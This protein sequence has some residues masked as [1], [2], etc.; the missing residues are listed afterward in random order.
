[1]NVLV[2]GGAGYLGGALT[3]LLLESAHNFRVYDSLVYE[4]CFLKEVDFIGGD[5]RDTERLKKQLSW[6]DVVIWLVGIVGDGACAID[7]DLTREI[8]VDAVKFLVNNYDGRIVYP[9][10]CSVY[11]AQHNVILTENSNTNPLSVYAVTK[12]E[13]EELLTDKNAIIYR[14]GTLFGLGDRYSR[15]RLD[16]VVN[17][18]V[19]KAHTLGK[20]TVFGGEQFRPLLHVKDVAKTMLYN[21]Q[22]SIKGIFNIHKQNTRIMD[23][24][25]Q[26][27]NH[28]PDVEVVH[29][30][31]K[32][33]DSRNYRVSSDK[34]YEWLVFKPQYTI[35]D[36]IEEL[37]Y[38][39][40][41]NRIK[42]VNN[43]RFT[44]QG[45][46]RKLLGG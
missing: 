3:D 43:I 26:V 46:M 2:V 1:M 24:A 36:G 28:F 21:L 37:K 29:T 12:L 31:M 42:D 8:N 45:F 16:L 11:G 19:V 39:L 32:F 4:D 41:Q 14:L 25:H 5:V 6:A 15:I 22:P 17:T 18:L 10:T 23:I 13:A 7:P 9:S 20:L 34:A 30:E 40:E 44:N 33:E 38:L 35:D 27:R